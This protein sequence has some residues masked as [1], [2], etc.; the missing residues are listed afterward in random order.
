[1]VVTRDVP[2]GPQKISASQPIL[3]ANSQGYFD[4]WQVDHEAYNTADAGKHDK[5]TLPDHGT[6]PSTGAGEGVVY[7]LP[8]SPDTGR[9]DLYYRYQTDAGT[10]FTGLPYPLTWIKAFGRCTTAGPVAGACFNITGASRGVSDV[11]TITLTNAI[12][13]VADVGNIVVLANNETGTTPSS[14]AGIPVKT[15]TSPTIIQL[16]GNFN[17][18]AIHIVVAVM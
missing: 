15:I 14:T 3:L 12:C 11:W 7:T 16:Q 6:A 9:V 17:F 13:D 10:P 2:L 18:N 5:V 1:M 4:T 8:N